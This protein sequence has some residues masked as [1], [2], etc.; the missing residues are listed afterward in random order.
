MTKLY[1]ATLRGTGKT[2]VVYKLLLGGY[3]NANDHTTTYQ[4]TQIKID[5]EVTK[6][7]TTLKKMA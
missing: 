4:D 7:R 5:E 3:C 2:V 1:R 6:D